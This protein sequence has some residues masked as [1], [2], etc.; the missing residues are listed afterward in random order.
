MNSFLGLTV[1]DDDDRKLLMGQSVLKIHRLDSKKYSPYGW[2]GPRGE[3]SFV[4]PVESP[5]LTDQFCGEFMLG[6]VVPC[7][8]TTYAARV[9]VVRLEAGHV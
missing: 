6:G 4:L 7:S 3:Q 5:T 1:R 8:L 9:R 2:F